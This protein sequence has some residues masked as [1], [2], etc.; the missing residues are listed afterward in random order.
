[1]NCLR[2]L[3][4]SLSLL[5]SVVGTAF[6]AEEIYDPAGCDYTPC[7]APWGAGPG[8]DRPWYG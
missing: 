2:A 1:M 4:L 6:A 5:L 8:D 3:L 7:E